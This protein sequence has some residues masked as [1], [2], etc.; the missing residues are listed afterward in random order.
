[1]QTTT[2]PE[3]EVALET[4]LGQIRDL[5]PTP[6]EGELHLLWIDAMSQPESVLPFVAAYLSTRV[7]RAPS[8]STDAMRLAGAE[9]F[10]AA[11]G[12]SITDGQVALIYKAMRA[13]APADNREP[14]AY[15]MRNM[16]VDGTWT[17]WYDV[18]KVVGQMNLADPVLDIQV[19][20]LFA[21]PEMQPTTPRITMEKTA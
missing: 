5:F 16:D 17:P 15:Q 18:P 14:D 4:A 8:E 3:R 13:A 12:T 2:M 6:K 10:L 21:L 9:A 20:T 7:P 11:D 1:M 19:R